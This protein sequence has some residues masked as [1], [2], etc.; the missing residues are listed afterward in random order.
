MEDLSLTHPGMGKTELA[1]CNRLSAHHGLTLTQTDLV[2]LEE[3]RQSALRETG[4]VEFSGGVLAKL[5][6][7][8]CVSPYLDQCDYADTL[9]T[10]QELFYEFKNLCGERLEDDELIAAMTVIFDGT[11]GSLD[12]LSGADAETLYAAARTGRFEGFTHD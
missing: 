10:L 7:A 6:D 1:R 9:E 5:A 2:R 12:A 11:G 3:A 4:R 8:F